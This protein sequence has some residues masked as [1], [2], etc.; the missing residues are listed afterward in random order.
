MPPRIGLVEN[1]AKTWNLSQ[2]GDRYSLQPP[3]DWQLREA[4]GHTHLQRL[5]LHYHEFLESIPG[6]LG[7]DIILDWIDNNPAWRPSYWLDSWNCYAV[8]I[9]CVC[10]MQWYA[11]HHRLLNDQ[12]RHKVLS[13]L[14]EQISFLSC[15]LETDICGNHLIKNI[16]CLLWASAFFDGPT[17]RKWSAIG[18]RLL[19]EQLPVQLLADG[20]HFE[21]S[22][23]YH[24]QVFVDLLECAGILSGND[25][26]RLMHLL[27]PAAQAISDL[28]HPDGFISLFSDG[29]MEMVYSP[30]EC[31]LA[32]AKLGGKS[33]EAKQAIRLSNAGYFGA[34]FKGSYFLADCGAIC[35]DALPAHGHADM[36]AFEWDV[37]GKRVI[38][39]ASVAEYESGEKR[40]WGRSTVAHNT[41]TVGDRNQAE[42]FGSFRTGRRSCASVDHYHFENGRLQLG[43]HYNVNLGP[44]RFAH[45]RNF[46]VSDGQLSISDRLQGNMPGAVVSR[47]LLH[48]LCSLEIHDEHHAEITIEGTRIQLSSTRRLTARQVHWS[49]N[50]GQWISTWQIEI[51]Y[52]ELPCEG[53]LELQVSVPHRSAAIQRQTQA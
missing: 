37:N 50:F 34:R 41:V 29:G 24:C 52:G 13:S 16:R 47:L 21:L 8:S 4:Q 12:Q 42:M 40:R 5:A 33:I 11:E 46:D 30:A 23:A 22:P 51:D 49:P 7:R 26:D 1:Q 10:W 9:R 25:R 45:W 31:L 48:H 27:T 44:H 43:G 20:V 2:L 32:W 19:A 36:L 35:A 28:T 17:A 6:E 14:A 3:I 53:K 39:D 18:N 38:V 15:N